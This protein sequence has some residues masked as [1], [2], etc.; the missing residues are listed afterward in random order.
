L[1]RE[2]YCHNQGLKIQDMGDALEEWDVAKKGLWVRE[3][4]DK[5]NFLF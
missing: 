2:E 5:K 4:S 3:D 1:L